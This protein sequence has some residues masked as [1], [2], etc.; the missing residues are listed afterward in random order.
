MTS[1]SGT[2]AEL[3][4]GLFVHDKLAIALALS[5]LGVAAASWIASYYLMPFMM[6]SNSGMMMSGT[7]VAS[8]VSSSSALSITA[9]ALFEIIWIVGMVAMMFPAMIP[10]VLFYNRI[11]TKLEPNPRLA[12]A[13]GTPLFLSGYLIT[14]AILG[15]GA[16]ILV[17]AALNL[18]MY[19]SSSL[20]SILAIEASAAILI[21]TGIYQ[22]TPLK[23]KC[24]SGCVS[25]IGFFATKSKKGLIGSLWMGF[26]HGIYCV[27]CCMLYM[28]VMLVVGA[29]SLPVMAI[30]AGII[31][32]EKVV[33]RGSVW[34]ARIVGVG[35]IL[36]GI[37]VLA[38]PSLLSML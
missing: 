36:A 8:I 19:F 22:F 33:I 9:I 20:L 25:P 21:A 16:Y 31:A 1:S 24:L 14:Y 13:I 3:A 26:D 12:R 23:Y 15:L 35:F 29:M 10:I 7:G 32:L 17:Y 38:H 18:S 37:M 6:M 2:D 34:F 28:I 5:L 4:L 27:G 11:A 30:L